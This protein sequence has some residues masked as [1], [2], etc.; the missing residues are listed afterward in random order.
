VY[1]LKVIPIVFRDTIN[2]TVLV[3]ALAQ[4]LVDYVP[5]KTYKSEL[6]A[7]CSSKYIGTLS[8]TSVNRFPI[9]A[10]LDRIDFSTIV[11]FRVVFLTTL[12]LG[13]Q[14]PVILEQEYYISSSGI[15]LYG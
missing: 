1:V 4:S 10:P 2:I 11:R 15:F 13:L 7:S 12:A 9:K 5:I 6:R 14:P 3:Q 8:L